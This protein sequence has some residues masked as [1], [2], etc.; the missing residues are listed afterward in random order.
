[1][2]FKALKNSQLVPRAIPK[3]RNAWVKSVPRSIQSWGGQEELIP[4]TSRPTRDHDEEAMV[5]P[6]PWVYHGLH[7]L[8]HLILGTTLRF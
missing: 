6:L 3:L 8:F 7:M 4:E 1:M 2:T 5:D